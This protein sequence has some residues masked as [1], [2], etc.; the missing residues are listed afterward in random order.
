METCQVM[1]KWELIQSMSS[2][3]FIEFETIYTMCNTKEEEEDTLLNTLC[4]FFHS[5]VKRGND[6]WLKI[7]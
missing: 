7:R 3:I 6:K 5:I 2:G 1:F 4:L